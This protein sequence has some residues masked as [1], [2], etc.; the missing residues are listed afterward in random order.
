MEWELDF[1]FNNF[2]FGSALNALSLLFCFSS[3]L[4]F[5]LVSNNLL[6]SGMLNPPRDEVRNAMLSCMTAGIR[7]IV[8]TGDNK[9]SNS[10]KLYCSFSPST[11]HISSLKL[12]NTESVHC[13]VT[14]PQDRCFWSI[15]RF[16][17]TFLH[18]FWVWRTSST[19]TNYSIATYGTFYQVYQF[20]SIL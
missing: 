14:L 9:V 20:I 17:W 18:C 19:A 5:P 1:F 3:I 10:C 13:W 11:F 2:L 15:D 7:V 4:V 6:F 16:C 12:L 8:V